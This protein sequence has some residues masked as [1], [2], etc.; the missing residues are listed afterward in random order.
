METIV[1]IG[2]PQKL[3]QRVQ[4]LASERHQAVPD[5]LEEAIE[6]VESSLPV[7][8]KEDHQMFLEEEAYQTMHHELMVQFVGQYVAI[9][10]GKVVDNDQ[11]EMALLDRI[12]ARFPQ[13]IVLLKQVQPLPEPDIFVRSPRLI[14][15]ES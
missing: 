9:F 8:D 10:Q 3:F 6:L 7:D 15:I 12:N 4:A 14:P 11:D 5:L 2:I 13:Q 1:S